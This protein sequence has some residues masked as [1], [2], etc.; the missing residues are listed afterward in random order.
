[1]NKPAGAPQ[2]IFRRCLIAL[3]ALTLAFSLGADGETGNAATQTAQAIQSN[4]DLLQFVTQVR[5]SPE[6]R[7][8]VRQEVTSSMS[9]APQNVIRRDGLIA[10]TLTNAARNPKDAPRLRELWRYD[11]AARVPHSDIEYILS[12]KYDPVVIF[13]EPH[14]RI[15]TGATLIALRD[16]TVWFAQKLHKPA[17]DGSFI[18]GERAWLKSSYGHLTDDVQD[19][20][21]HVGRNCPHTMDFFSGVVAAQRDRFFSENAKAVGNSA[22]A[23]TDAALIS[24]IVYNNL[25]HRGG[26][27]AAMNGRV[28]DYM[29]Q[30]SLLQQQLQRTV[31]RNPSL[32]PP[33]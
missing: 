20:Y 8:Q 19:A 3:V 5:L 29:V 13:D 1:M 7:G 25:L 27:A 11:I 14:Q 26:G 28:F 10:T 30:Q 15:I 9:S 24:R 21:A 16:C 31:I 33:D 17:P 4:I 12:E 2:P 22:I 18:A 23:A 6:E 32:P